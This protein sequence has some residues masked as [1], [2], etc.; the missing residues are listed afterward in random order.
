MAA[1]PQAEQLVPGHM[2]TVLDTAAP[3]ASH[4]LGSIA[5]AVTDA[6]LATPSAALV[7]L[8]AVGLVS[9][10]LLMGA[11]RKQRPVREDVLDALP[12]AV[13]LFDATGRLTAANRKLLA[14]FPI[15]VSDEQLRDSSSFDIYAQLS[16]DN[17]AIERARNRAR[18]SRNPDATLAFELASFGRNS[19][20]IKERNTKDGGTAIA[21][22]PSNVASGNNTRF[23]SLTALPTR[24]QLVSVL[25]QRCARTDNRLGLVIVD[26]K[27]FRQINDTYG[28][29]AGDELLKQTA[30]CL[31]HAMP[32]TAL[33]SRTAGDE[34]AVLLEFAGAEDDIE[35]RVQEVLAALQQGLDVN[36]MSVPV[37]ASV[38]IAYAPEHGNTVSTLLT[39]ADSACADAKRLGNNRLVVYSSSRQQEAK[40]RHK[41]EVGLQNAIERNELSVQYQPQVDIATQHTSGMEALVRWNSPEFGRVSPADFIPIAEQTGIITRI[42]HWVLQQSVADYQRLARYGGSPATLSVNLSRKQFE[43]NR[44]VSEIGALLEQTGFDPANL[45]LEITET[46]L[47]DDSSSLKGILADL[48][49]FGA[50]IA[51]DDFGVGYSSLLELRDFPISE[52]KID[53][54][55]ITDITTDANS[56]DIVHAI[57]DIARSIGADVVAEGIETQEQYDTVAALGCDRVQGYWLCRPMPATTFPDLLLTS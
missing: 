52:V 50:K 15:E 31:Q 19:L 1:E 30:I 48:T 3:S 4:S 23:D 22:Y 32:E 17:L 14:L 47:F 46:A 43:D 41:L 55:F 13:A 33:I 34:F 36:N 51:I 16:P 5:Q 6:Y 9:G 18:D 53:R 37:R 42:G 56:Q 25:A 35:R 2:R 40:R 20:L 39:A 57:V 38:G 28:R 10:A 24:T 45:C 21:V 12:D 49:G 54:A 8:V 44:I 27:G 11:T 26:L 29:A 7:G